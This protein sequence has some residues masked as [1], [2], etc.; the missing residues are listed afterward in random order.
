M[1]KTDLSDFFITKSQAADFSD[2]LA[3]VME[4]M[5][6]ANFNAEQSLGEE[7]GV[8]K[9]DKLLR[10]LHEKKVTNL[11]SFIQSL[12][13]EINNLP[14]INLTFAIEPSESILKAIAQW[15]QVNLNQQIL[16][17]YRVD[18]NLIAGVA[19]NYQGKFKDY[20]IKP[21]FNEII[22]KITDPNSNQ[23]NTH[24]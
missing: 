17:E 20:S 13:K 1:D 2:R 9:R 12:I 24:S 16:I 6:T 19:I 11:K 10:L 4:S 7:F 8:D 5:F 21:I 15:F 23:I 18:K 3:K 22:K 14:N